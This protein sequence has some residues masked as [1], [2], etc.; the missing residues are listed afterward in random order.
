M[1]AGRPPSRGRARYR[2]ARGR[3]VATA[4]RHRRWPEW[5]PSIRAVDSNRR[6]I[7]SETSGRLRLP[8]GVWLPFE[9][10]SCIDRRWTWEVARV[11][12]TGHFVEERDAGCRVGFELPVL[13]SGYAPVCARALVKIERLL[14]EDK[15]E[16]EE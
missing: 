15:D 1:D 4:D 9:I 2:Y 11:P 6:V 3:G 12:G 14:V 5:G 16:D 8:G 10:T 7:D 13:A